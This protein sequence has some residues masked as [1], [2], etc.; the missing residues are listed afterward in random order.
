[1]KTKYLSVRPNLWVKLKGL[2]KWTIYKH[3]TECENDKCYCVGFFDEND[4]G[5]GY[6]LW[7]SGSTEADNGGEILTP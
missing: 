1:M 7:D 2:F 6:Y 3:I 4:G 5:Q